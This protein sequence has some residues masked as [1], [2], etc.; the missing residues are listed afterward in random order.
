MGS[1]H[2]VDASNNVLRDGKDIP[3]FY[4]KKGQEYFMY[5]DIECDAVKEP[6]KEDLD[7]LRPVHIVTHRTFYISKD[8][9]RIEEEAHAYSIGPDFDGLNFAQNYHF[10]E[11]GELRP[12]NAMWGPQDHIQWA[13]EVTD[14]QYRTGYGVTGPRDIIHIDQMRFLTDWKQ[15]TATNATTP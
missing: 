14:V 8:N 12:P 6:K 5:S 2:T 10:N 13:S 3:I 1:F 15:T 9:F 4:I 7:S 11:F